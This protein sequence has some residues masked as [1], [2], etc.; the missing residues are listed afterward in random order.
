M[1]PPQWVKKKAIAQAV[2]KEYRKLANT[3]SENAKYRYIQMCRALKTYG[4][5]TFEVQKK[6]EKPGQ[7]KPKFKKLILGVTRDSL[8]LMNADTKEIE[9]SFP[10]TH[11]K[12]WAPGART[13]TLDFGEYEEDYFT[14]QTLEG[15]AISQLIAGY[16]DIILKRT[17]DAPRIAMNS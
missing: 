16:I 6:I 4:I 17:K 12:R 9:K 8:V 14:V 5:T 10:L 13:F 15:E 11:L 7:K 2:L 3:D 1:L